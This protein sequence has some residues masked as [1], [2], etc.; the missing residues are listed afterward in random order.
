MGRQSG[1][2]MQVACLPPSS[3][4]DHGIE[5]SEGIGFVAVGVI[6]VH[7][8]PAIHQVAEAIP[9]VCLQDYRDMPLSVATSLMQEMTLCIPT[10]ELTH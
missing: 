2:V 6:V 5:T 8:L 1:Q 10:I 3:G 4:A 7:P 9:P